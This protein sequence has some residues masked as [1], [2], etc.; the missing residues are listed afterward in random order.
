LLAQESFD[1][2][3]GDLFELLSDAWIRSADL[4]INAAVEY[5]GGISGDFTR[6]NL[7]EA[8]E[9]MD[10]FMGPQ[11]AER[12]SPVVREA[13]TLS[14]SLA[15]EDIRTGLSTS[16]NL[17]DR[18]A[19]GWLHQHDMYW[20]RTHFDREWT[21][22][23]AN[24]SEEAIKGGMSRRDAGNLFRDTLGGALQNENDHYWELVADAITTRSRSFGSIEAMVKADIMSYRWDSVVDHRTSDICQ[25]LDGKVFE[26]AAAVDVRDRMIAAQAPEEAKEIMPWLKP[27]EVLDRS[28]DQLQRLGV[29]MPPAHGNCRARVVIA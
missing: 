18:R 19:I 7:S 10:G 9:I 5:I 15:Q 13:V 17:V 26:V 23:I 29:V 14:Y 1:G 28:S 25:H 3:A 6:Q 12:V 21:E 22:R 11:M 16:F 8:I 2:I 4:A 24:L 27:D 20:T